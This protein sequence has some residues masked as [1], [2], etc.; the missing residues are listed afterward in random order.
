KVMYADGLSEVVCML[1][2]SLLLFTLL[3][4][5][6][7]FKTEKGSAK[8]PIV[9]SLVPSKD[10]KSLMLS[11]QELSAWLTKETGYH[12]DINIPTS[13]VAVVEAIGSKRVDIA[14]LNTTNYFLAEEKYGA[15]VQFITL[16]VDGN[17][18]YKGQFIVRTDSQM[19]SLE[20]LNGKKIAYVDPT[21]AS[22]YILPAYQLK[23]KNIKPAEAVF[24]GKHDSVVS[25]VYQKQ[26]DVGTTFY[27]LPEK[28]G[29]P[30]DARRLVAAQYPDVWEKLR[31]LDFTVSLAND[32]LVFRK[33]LDP[34][35]K[36]KLV[37]A[38]EKWSSTN[39]GKVTLKA[40]SNGS[41]LRRATEVDYRESR[42]IIKEMSQSLRE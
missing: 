14:Y 20:D 18:Q 34:E 15:E 41:G 37:K 17:S 6:C 1:K 23:T 2:I 29:E 27:A 16:N 12:F 38:I 30:M 10:T 42:K 39:E 4:T 22:G 11:A 33:D 7:T 40:L 19:K 3:L 36:D 9:I 31:I 21:S 13:Y 32:A 35:M 24:A 28:N 25:M 5:A 8:D 26:V